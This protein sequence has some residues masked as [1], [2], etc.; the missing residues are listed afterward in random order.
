MPYKNVSTDMAEKV[1]IV[2]SDGRPIV[3]F[4]EPSERRLPGRDLVNDEEDDDVDADVTP[5]S[6]E[7]VEDHSNSH[8][9]PRKSSLLVNPASHRP[10]TRKRSVTFDPVDVASIKQTSPKTSTDEEVNTGAS[11]S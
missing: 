7:I 6:I 10:Q 2:Q 8:V 11:D 9:R 5:K 4:D 3:I 1:K